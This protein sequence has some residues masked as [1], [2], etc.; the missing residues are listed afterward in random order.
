MHNPSVG[1][2][3]GCPL[4]APLF[5]LFLDGLHHEVIFRTA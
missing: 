3:Q 2:R 4:S 1:L 5:G